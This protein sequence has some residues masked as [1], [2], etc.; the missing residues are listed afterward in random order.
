MTDPRHDALLEIVKKLP[1]DFQPWGARS[2]EDDYG[3][4]CSSGCRW[5]VRLEPGLQPDWGICR[6]AASPRSGLLTFEH[7]GCR[8]FEADEGHERDA[9]PTARDATRRRAEVALLRNLSEREDELRRALDAASDHWGYEDPVYRFYHQSFKV[10]W[11]Q[12][13]TESLFSLLVALAPPEAQ[14]DRWFLAIIRSG[15]GREFVPEDNS[16]WTEVTRPIVEAFFHARYFVEMAVRYAKLAEPPQLLPS[17]YAALLSLYG[18][19]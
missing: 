17:G 5:Y 7:Q 3:G 19:R 14:L 12:K 4:D 1:S 15:T 10:Y 8:Q 11:L 16:R 9:E 18:L 6:N 2:R 13:R